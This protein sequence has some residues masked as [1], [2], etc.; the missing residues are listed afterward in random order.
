MSIPNSDELTAVNSFRHSH[1]DATQEG[2][3]QRRRLA[4]PTA[5]QQLTAVNLAPVRNEKEI[6]RISPDTLAGEPFGRGDVASALPP[7]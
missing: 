4:A 2:G 3:A 5:S 7:A 6:G 1:S